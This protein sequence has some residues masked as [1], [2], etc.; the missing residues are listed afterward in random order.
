MRDRGYV[1]APVHVPL[2]SKDA[3]DN[4]SDENPSSMFGVQKTVA[5]ALKFHPSRIFV[6]HTFKRQK[7]LGHVFM[8]AKLI[9][10]L[11][12][13]RTRFIFRHL[14]YYLC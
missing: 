2:G 11:S 6:L 3:E 1:P 12:S 10:W 13:D 4:L 14:W 7:E 9:G 5:W 8:I